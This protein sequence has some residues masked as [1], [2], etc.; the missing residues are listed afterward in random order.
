MA[1]SYEFLLLCFLSAWETPF[2]KPKASSAVSQHLGV[3]WAPI[4]HR[5]WVGSQGHTS[6]CAASGLCC[7][8]WKTCLRSKKVTGFCLLS[9][10][11]IR[12]P[13]GHVDYYVNGGQDQP[14]CPSFLHAGQN[15]PSAFRLTQP[16]WATEGLPSIN[17]L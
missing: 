9:D 16:V 12:I 14:G 17:V 10:L 1:S 4:E 2:R 8:T 3:R 6:G 15:S 13:V 7:G 5:E 11:G